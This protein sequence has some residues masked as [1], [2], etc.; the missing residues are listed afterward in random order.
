MGWYYSATDKSNRNRPFQMT[1]LSLILVLALLVVGI[2]SLACAGDASTQ[3]PGASES[4]TPIADQAFRWGGFAQAIATVVAIG[5]GGFFA[6]RRGIIFRQEKPHLT[7]THEITHRQ[8][9]PG[10]IH[11]E[12]AVTLANTSR[13]KVDVRDGLFSIEQIAPLTD[14][15]V[16]YVFVGAFMSERTY[17]RPVWM[18]LKEPRLEW[19]KDELTV[20]P[21]ERF[22]E[23]YEYLVPCFVESVLHLPNTDVF[24]FLLWK[25][26]FTICS[27]LSDVALLVQCED[28]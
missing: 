25:G 4:R 12:I 18:L 5:L 9:S 15:Y 24:N 7:I 6:W 28:R 2:A 1:K 13:V 27:C 20:E 19:E 14:E 26:Y 22:V 17:V 16:E 3:S 10:Y 21:G 11:L 8:V 23:T